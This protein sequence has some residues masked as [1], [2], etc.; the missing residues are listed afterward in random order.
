MKKIYFFLATIFFANVS[1]GQEWIE[2]QILGTSE[3]AGSPFRSISIYENQAVLCQPGYSGKATVYKPDS[4]GVWHAFQELYPVDTMEIKGFGNSVSIHAN[5]IIIGATVWADSLSTGSAFIFERDNLG[6]WKQIQ[7][8]TPSDGQSNDQFG[9][10]VSINSKYAVIGA[11]KEDEDVFGNNTLEEAGSAYIYERDSN[12][13]WNQ[14]QKITASDRGIGDSFGYSVAIDSNYIVVGAPNESEDSLAGNTINHAG[15]AYIYERNT[16]GIWGQIKKIVASDRIMNMKFGH[17]VAISK[18]NILI[19]SLFSADKT[20]GAYF[21]EKDTNNNKWHLI[22][23]VQA[24]DQLN[25]KFLTRFG[26]SVSIN[27]NL[28]I[29]GAP[30]EDGDVDL[31]HPNTQAGSAYI[32]EKDIDGIWSPLDKIMAKDRTIDMRFGSSVAISRNLAITTTPA[33]KQIHN[34]IRPAVSGSS[35]KKAHFFNLTSEQIVITDTAFITKPACDMNDGTIDIEANGGTK[36]LSYHWSTALGNGASAIG[37]RAGEYMVTIEDAIGCTLIDTVP[38]PHSNPL[39]DEPHIYLPNIFSPD[40]D[41]IND[42]FYVFGKKVR[43]HTF[44]IYDRWGKRVFESTDL[45]TGWDGT[46]NGKPLAT[47]VYAY[48]VTGTYD[49]N[50]PIKQKGNITLVR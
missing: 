50:E 25:P 6:I 40:G 37:L 41:G 24:W 7:K 18:T 2:T 30:T 3:T 27:E 20:S 13:S 14:V 15:S 45:S 44:M 47:G 4:C 11:D 23:K 42:V 10:S 32:F 34:S 29:I 48:V 12:G 21:F 33:K 17:Q 31:S 22:Q 16:N 5:Y 43:E 1:F 9:I 28:A 8:V 36:P 35:I 26:E 49:N 38:L 19:G 39:C 46:H